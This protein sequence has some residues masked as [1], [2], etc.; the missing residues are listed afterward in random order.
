MTKN[1]AAD[2]KMR[3]PQKID[4]RADETHEF[5]PTAWELKKS[6][7]ITKGRFKIRTPNR[8][9]YKRGYIRQGNFRNMLQ[10]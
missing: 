3:S 6:A 4:F 9:L 10:N 8:I 5:H 1:H 2:S 7:K